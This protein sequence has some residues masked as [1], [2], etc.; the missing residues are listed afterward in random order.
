MR[1]KQI[2]TEDLWVEVD[3]V[4]RL[5]ARAGKPIPPEFLPFV[6][7]DAT[8]PEAAGPPSVDEV[9]LEAVKEF[10][11]D[12][13][14]EEQLVEILF[15]TVAGL[16]AVGIDPESLTEKVP[17]LKELVGGPAAPDY[18]SAD[19]DVLEKLI[20]DRKAALEPEGTGANGNVTK[21]DLVTALEKADGVGLG[22]GE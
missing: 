15:A 3:G 5:A 16:A 2:A 18:D 9:D 14:D 11:D 19:K 4:R 13:D 17:R 8:T 21:P 7:E 6:D 22:A 20:E 12:S 1:T 10:I